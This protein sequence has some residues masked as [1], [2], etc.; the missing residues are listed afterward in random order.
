MDQKDPSGSCG[1]PPPSRND[2]LRKAPA[3]LVHCCTPALSLSRSLGRQ[4]AL[5][6]G[7][8]TISRQ[9]DRPRQDPGQSK[10]AIAIAGLQFLAGCIQVCPGPRCLCSFFSPLPQN[11]NPFIPL[12][13]LTYDLGLSFFSPPSP[14]QVVSVNL[15]FQPSRLRLVDLT[16]DSA[17]DLLDLGIWIWILWTLDSVL[18]SALSA[19]CSSLHCDC[20]ICGQHWNTHHHTTT[21]NIFWTFGSFLPSIFYFLIQVTL[22]DNTCHLPPVT[23]Q[24]HNNQTTNTRPT[25]SQ[26]HLTQLSSPRLS[27]RP[28]PIS[29]NPTASA[30]A[31]SSRQRC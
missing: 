24:P 7:I 19:L 18:C 20:F 17:F 26:L 21:T 25:N 12:F 22:S 15:S 5:F 9:A 3:N 4:Q 8:Q 31:I 11:K 6:L 23:N 27:H 10:I 13:F 28:S 16:L 1:T 30:S 14:C 2:S 29:T